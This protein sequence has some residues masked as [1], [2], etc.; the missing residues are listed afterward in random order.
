MKEEK[1]K[2]FSKSVQMHLACAKDDPIRPTMCCVYI[3]NG[4]AYA[5]DGIVW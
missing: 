4:Y 5:T 3:K 1:G 2:N